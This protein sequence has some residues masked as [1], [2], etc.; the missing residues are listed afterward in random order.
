MAKQAV[1]LRLDPETLEWADAYAA[2]RD[3]SRQVVLES[4]V[5]SF[6]QD[7]EAGV[8]E[9]RQTAR[10]QSSVRDDA[11]QGVGDCPKREGSLGHVWK[12]ASQDITR[13]C[14]YCGT[15]GRA[16]RNAAGEI[17]EPGYFDLATK[18]RAELYARIGAA[19]QARKAEAKG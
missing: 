2:E 10:A 4:A 13:P 12:A 16:K 8:P 17:I 3:T 11:E 14:R 5:A 6:R 18:D 1:A 7:C 19:Q 15:L 9:L